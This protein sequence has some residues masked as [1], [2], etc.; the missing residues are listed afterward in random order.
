MHE[1]VK[2]TLKRKPRQEI[3][4]AVN[5]AYKDMLFLCYLRKQVNEKLISENRHYCT[6]SLLLY[7]ELNSLLREQSLDRQM[8]WNQIKVEMEMPYPQD[9]AA[10]AAAIDAAKRH[11]VLTWEALEEGDELSQWVLESFVAEGGTP[12][13]DGAYLMRGGTNTSYMTVPTGAEVRDLFPDAQ[14]YQKF[15]VSMALRGWATGA[16]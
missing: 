9:P 4:I 8:K 15:L 11:H 14:S 2:Q 16:A 6:M 10:A 5:Q 3:D 13:P 12:L 7:R 1:S